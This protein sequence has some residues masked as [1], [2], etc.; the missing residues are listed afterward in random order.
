[1]HE[2]FKVSKY[3][4]KIKFDK[5]WGYQNGGS[6]LNG[7]E[8]IQTFYHLCQTHKIFRVDKYYE[9]IKFD[10]TRW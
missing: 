4:V 6:P 9:K 5:F 8:K 1:M 10:K 3:K 2:I 7:A